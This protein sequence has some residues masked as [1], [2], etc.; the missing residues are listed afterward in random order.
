MINQVAGLPV[1][2]IYVVYAMIATADIAL[3]LK[4]ARFSNP[5]EMQLEAK[6]NL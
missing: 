2:Y 6:V 3:D 4:P 5:Q 1:F